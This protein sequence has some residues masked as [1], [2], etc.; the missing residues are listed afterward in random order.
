MKEKK[1]LVDYFRLFKKDE[2]TGESKLNTKTMGVV[3]L[4]GIAIMGIV[5]LGNSKTLTPV[6]TTPKITNQNT[7]ETVETFKQ[8]R[9]TSPEIAKEEGRYEQQLKKM[10]ETISGVKNVSVMVNLEASDTQILEKN[11]NEHTQIT[12][13][14]DKTGGKRKIESTKKDQTAV[15]LKEDG[16]EK[17]LVIKTEKAD[18]KGVLVVADGVEN[19]EVKQMV[20]E[21]VT[22]VLG[23]GSNRVS[24]LPMKR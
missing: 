24:V 12:E 22:R 8:N 5:Q 2:K 17:P 19:I 20:I 16:K 7:E 1:S 23:V 13:E 9:N 18:V 4:V 14:T 10:L 15:I 11:T 21:A 6:Q 3:L